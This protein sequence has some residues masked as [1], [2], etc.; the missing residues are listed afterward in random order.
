[1]QCLYLIKRGKPHCMAV[2]NAYVPSM[3]QLSEYCTT[4]DHKKCPFYLTVINRERTLQ[5][6]Y[7]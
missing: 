7:K 5:R 1:M 3:F 4:K 6:N 2:N